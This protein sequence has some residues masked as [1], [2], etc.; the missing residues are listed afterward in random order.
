MIWSPEAAALD[1]FQRI[2]RYYAPLAGPGAFGLTD[3]AAVIPGP[4]G[5]DLVLKA[6]AIVETVHFLE[7]DPPGLVAQKL[8]RVNLSDLAAKGAEPVGYLL[9]TA[10]PS[11]C[12]DAWVEAFTNGLAADQK[13]FGITLLGGDSDATPG[14]ICLSVT[15]IGRVPRGRMVR[16][17]GARPGDGVFVSGTIG[18]GAL[19]L[20]AIRGELD[21]ID[22]GHRDY[23]AG[24][25][26]L[27]QPRSALGP[28]LRDV[29]HAMLDVSDGLVADLGH[30]C[31]VSGVAAIVELGR[32][33]LSAA[34]RAALARMPGL[35]EIVLGG[36]DDYEL[37]FAAPLSSRPELERL[38]AETGVPIT[39]IGRIELGE[40]ARVVDD[41]GEEIALARAGY[42][43]F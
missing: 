7:G 15:A 39:E 33:P 30:L 12:D 32:V 11:R 26:R 38:A 28:R 1:E 21:P 18:D 13:T 25:Y 14:P 10:L 24:R 16:R 19:G 36:G 37:L 4:D 43:H 22:A 23:L 27:P 3:D 2:A 41:R 34:A 8:L 6:D 42:R 35:L 5:T 9:T 31:A 20:K 29:A 40:G 17:A